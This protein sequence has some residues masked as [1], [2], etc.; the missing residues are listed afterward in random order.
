MG[1]H[2]SPSV[3]CDWNVGYREEE[4]LN[5]SSGE[6]LEGYRGVLGHPGW[7]SSAMGTG[8]AHMPASAQI[9]TGEADVA[10]ALK[11]SIAATQRTR[12]NR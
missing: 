1:T 5:R 12:K 11:E 10:E 8:E 7:D 6:R 3:D 9:V 2:S 4:Q